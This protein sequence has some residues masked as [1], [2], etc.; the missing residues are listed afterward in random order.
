MGATVMGVDTRPPWLTPIVYNDSDDPPHEA[1]RANDP[2]IDYDRRV[3]RDEILG[4]DLDEDDLDD[5]DADDLG[6]E[7]GD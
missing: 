6:R 2:P 5:F 7:G 3:D 4:E 1:N